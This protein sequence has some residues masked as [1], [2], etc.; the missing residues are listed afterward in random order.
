MEGDAVSENEETLDFSEKF[1]LAGKARRYDANLAMQAI[2]EMV[3]EVDM[4]TAEKNLISGGK[5][6][7]GRAIDEE[8]IIEILN[9]FPGVDRRFERIVDG[10]YSDY[11]H[12][13]EEIAATIEVAKEEA[14]RTGRSGVIAVY[15]P[16]QNTRQHEVFDG[17][18][19]AFLGVEKLFWLPTY[20][21]RENPKLEVLTP[22][23]FIASLANAEVGE[24][25][26]MDTELAEKLTELRN[27]GKLVVL[28]T[29]GP[30]DKWLRENIK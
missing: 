14:E 28:M 27:E 25:A 19:E 26:E 8:L 20:L 29:A 15:E 30:A 22:K 5:D 16:H 2:F 24:P 3:E 9:D 21:T 7:A 12:H 11:G 6:Y 17:Y 18:K 4:M 13:P 1:N 23:D 10:V